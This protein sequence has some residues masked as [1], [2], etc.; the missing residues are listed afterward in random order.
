MLQ[1]LL[2]LIVVLPQPAHLHNKTI[3]T[4]TTFDQ[5]EHD[6]VRSNAGTLHVLFGLPNPY[7]NQRTPF[8]TTFFLPQNRHFRVTVKADAFYPLPASTTFTATGH[9][10]IAAE[11]LH[12]T[13]HL[14]TNLHQSDLAVS[15]AHLLLLG[16]TRG[17]GRW[18]RRAESVGGGGGVAVA[19]QIF[20]EWGVRLWWCE[21]GEGCTLTGIAS[22]IDRIQSSRV[23]DGSGGVWSKST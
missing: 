21:S 10:G 22:V 1:L 8:A 12:H 23:N 14:S 2:L 15:A 3:S 13:H 6:I 7:T 18:E 11:M 9:A 17:M 4:V 20:D 5:T 16:D 19:V